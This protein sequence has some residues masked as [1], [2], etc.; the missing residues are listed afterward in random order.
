MFMCLV[1]P[2]VKQYLE[3]VNLGY[4]FKP[5]NTTDTTN[6]TPDTMSQPSTDLQPVV[7][8]P[9]KSASSAPQ[10]QTSSGTQAIDQLATSVT[11]DGGG[12]GY[13]SDIQQTLSTWT[14]MD[15]ISSGSEVG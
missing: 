3:E 5:G 6:T 7:A 2:Q 15:T 1:F 13:S 8:R 4:L 12:G 10:T 14:T 9:V 11:S